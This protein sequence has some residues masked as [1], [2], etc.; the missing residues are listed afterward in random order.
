M[1]ELKPEMTVRVD[2]PNVRRPAT[3]TAF[4]RRL[5][6]SE[7]RCSAPSWRLRWSTD[8]E[9]ES[10][11]WLAWSTTR[12]NCT[13]STRTMREGVLPELSS[14]LFLAIEGGVQQPKPT[15][16]FSVRADLA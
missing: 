12:G 1:T 8:Y 2:Q 10:Y 7:L 3:P 5:R 15:L 13:R 6:S 9:D 11:P 16:N 4:L 14:N